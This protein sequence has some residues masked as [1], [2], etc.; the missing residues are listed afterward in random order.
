LAFTDKKGLLVVVITALIHTNNFVT[1]GLSKIVPSTVDKT[2]L[3][4]CNE[5]SCKPPPL[6]VY[7]GNG[8]L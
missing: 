8:G 1:A 6:I 3:A 2:V 5:E 4:T 7:A